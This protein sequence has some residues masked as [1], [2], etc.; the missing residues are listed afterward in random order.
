VLVLLGTRELGE[1]PLL[2]WLA[3]SPAARRARVA[4]PKANV[5]GKAA[6]VMQF[7]TVAVLLARAPYVDVWI[8]A[9]AALGVVAAASY[10]YRELRNRRLAPRE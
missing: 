4:A 2:F 7:A 3:T 8:W 1:L 9:T 10:W 6:T 5:L